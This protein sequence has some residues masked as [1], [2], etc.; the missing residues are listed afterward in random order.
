M[1]DVDPAE[2]DADA[3]QEENILLEELCPRVLLTDKKTTNKKDDLDLDLDLLNDDTGVNAGNDNEDTP[4]KKKR[5][6]ENPTKGAPKTESLPTSQLSSSEAIE[7][8]TIGA[9]KAPVKPASK[10]TQAPPKLVKATN[11][12]PSN[13]P[14]RAQINPLPPL[15]P[16]P[17]PPKEAKK[18]KKQEGEFGPRGR[19]LERRSRS[20]ERR[21]RSGSSRDRRDRGQATGE[22]HPVVIQKRDQDGDADLRDQLKRRGHYGGRRPGP[23]VPGHGPRRH[24]GPSPG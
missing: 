19:T 23:P 24:P 11:A 10:K 13:V 1:A 7:V 15:I 6:K 8:I 12:V 3:E 17:P 2:Y 20:R 9:S 22:P 4:D 5:H 14:P 21:S 16:A 18:E